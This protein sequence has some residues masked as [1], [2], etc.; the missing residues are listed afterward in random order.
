MKRSER[1]K[2][3]TAIAALT[4]ILAGVLLLALGAN[5]KVQ[6]LSLLANGLGSFLIAS[7]AIGLIFEFWQLR[8]LL[9]DLNEQ[10]RIIHEVAA[11]RL[12]G[13]SASF[14]DSVPWEKLFLESTRLD[15]V[16]AYAATWRN[17]HQN[18]LERFLR[19]RDTQVQVVLPDPNQNVVINE[20]AH[21]FGTTPE[22]LK[23]RIA[24]AED[25]FRTLGSAAQGTVRIFH[26]GR[27]FTLTLYRFN[28]RAVLTTYRL[29]PNRGSVL[30]LVG[31]RGGELYEWVRDQWYGIL[32]D[33]QE[34]GITQLIYDNKANDQNPE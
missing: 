10:A 18:H 12:S 25:F 4:L 15:M 11:A 2:L 20:M 31:D 3:R 24:E 34:Q 29:P 13:F 22:Q 23:A 14:Y 19:R 7:V 16:F 21:R 1:Y 33:G 26:F 17:A 8:G 5:V 27:S 6:W 28:S 30:T 9:D 32:K